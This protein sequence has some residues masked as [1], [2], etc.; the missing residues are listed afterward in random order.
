VTHTVFFP[1]LRGDISDMCLWS[2]QYFSQ[3]SHQEVVLIQPC[4]QSQPIDA[5]GWLGQEV[6][7]CDGNR[8]DA[9]EGSRDQSPAS[10]HEVI[11]SHVESLLPLNITS[12]L[13]FVEDGIILRQPLYRHH[14][15]KSEDIFDRHRD[16]RKQGESINDR[17]DGIRAVVE[18][19]QIN[20]SPVSVS[21]FAVR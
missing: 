4:S 5:V 9:F 6:D 13:P 14:H 19:R 12:S 8:L 7:H 17:R 18:Q 20:S 10:T 21:S 2:Y 11:F 1:R 16:K 15:S 3:C